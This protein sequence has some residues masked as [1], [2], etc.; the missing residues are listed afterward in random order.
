MTQRQ[1]NDKSDKIN[2]VPTPLAIALNKW[3]PREI[4]CQKAI[5]VSFLC[6]NPWVL[7][8]FFEY[9]ARSLMARVQ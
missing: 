3:L 6:D 9:R 1:K 5:F 7:K 2:T 4:S 8:I